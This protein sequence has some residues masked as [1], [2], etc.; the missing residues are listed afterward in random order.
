MTKHQLFRVVTAAVIYNKEGLFLI[1]QRHS[2]DENQPG[3]W[4]IPAG[5]VEISETG[6]HTLEENLKREVLEE[7]GVE[8][9]IEKYLDS[10]SW[11]T[12]D[13]KKITIVFL[14]TISKGE[15]EPLSET[16]DIKWLNLE[17]VKKLKTAPNIVRLIEKATKVIK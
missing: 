10:H 5:H 12:E 8:I 7:I 13:Y 2:K 9:N 17:E 15:P 3:I 16:D 14:C 1:A 4:A 6:L 11:V